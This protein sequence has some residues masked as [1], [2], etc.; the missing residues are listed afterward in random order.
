MTLLAQVSEHSNCGPYVHETEALEWT[1]KGKRNSVHDTLV[2]AF[3]R[4]CLSFLK[5]DEERER[6]RNR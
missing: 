3:A 2:R 4:E 1:M 5:M 6:R